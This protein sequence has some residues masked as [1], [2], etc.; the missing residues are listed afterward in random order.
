MYTI[1]QPSK[2]DILREF[3]QPKIFFGE[4]QRQQKRDQIKLILISNLFFYCLPIVPGEKNVKSFFLTS[5]PFFDLSR[6]WNWSIVGCTSVTRDRCYDFVNTFAKKSAKKL[7]FLTQNKAKLFKN[8]ITKLFLENFFAE[9][10]D[11]N[12]DP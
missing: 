6:S 4:F 8:L 9:N 1:W 12:I 11:H 10:C 5:S 7:E 2:A 3:S